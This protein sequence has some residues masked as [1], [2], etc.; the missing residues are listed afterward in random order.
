MKSKQTSN[1]A[2][3]LHLCLHLASTLRCA[4]SVKYAM[5]FEEAKNFRRI[6]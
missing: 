6:K 3:E 1:I 2:S 4:V 5:D